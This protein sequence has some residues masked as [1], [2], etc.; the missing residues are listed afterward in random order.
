MRFARY[1][2]HQSLGEEGKRRH[3]TLGNTLEAR[4]YRG[5]VAIIIVVIA[6]GGM[7]VEDM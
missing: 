1:L 5:L 4:D 6:L 2:G 3:C 7:G